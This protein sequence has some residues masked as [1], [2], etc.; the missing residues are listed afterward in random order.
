MSEPTATRT[1][2]VHGRPWDPAVPAD[3]DQPREDALRPRD[4]EAPGLRRASPAPLAPVV[5]P[6]SH[7]GES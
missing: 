7:G 6:P 3:A 2:A 4:P 5:T 1:T